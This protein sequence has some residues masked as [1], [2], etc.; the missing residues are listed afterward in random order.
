MNEQELNEQFRRA[1]DFDDL[2][3]ERF[4]KRQQNQS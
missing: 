1:V 4:A 3:E 2:L